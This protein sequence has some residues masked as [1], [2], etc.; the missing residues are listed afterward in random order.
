MKALQPENMLKQ[1]T[2]TRRT[3]GVFA[4]KTGRR[5]H[6]LNPAME[7]SYNTMSIHERPAGIEHAAYMD[8][9]APA[10]GGWGYFY[11]PPR[12]RYLRT[13]G[14]PVSGM[15]VAF[16]KSWGGFGGLKSRAQLEHECYTFVAGGSGVGI[17]DQLPP[18]GRLEAARYQRI[19]EVLQPIRAMEPLLCGAKPLTEAAIVLPPLGQGQLPS[20]EWAAAAKVLLEAKVQFDTVDRE[21]DWSR[22]PLLILPDQAHADAA[23]RRKLAAYLAAGGSVLATGLAVDALPA[24]RVKRIGG[25]FSAAAYYRAAP[26]LDTGVEPVPHVV[27]AGFLP[28]RT[29][30]AVALAT[31]TRAY[32]PRGPRFFFSSQ[33]P[34]AEDTDQGVVFQWNRLMYSSAPLFTEYWKTGYGAHRLLLVNCLR[35]LLPKPLVISNAPLAWEIALLRQG[36]RRLCVI[37]PYAPLRTGE[38][39]SQIAYCTP[40]MD[41][42][43]P[44]A[45]L[46][47]QVRGCFK[48]AHALARKIRVSIA[49][50]QG[51]SRLT[52]PVADGP[53]I[54]VMER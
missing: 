2:D 49:P 34:Y 14:R 4:D 10:T 31:L 27:R 23:F 30:G 26:G 43:T 24:D 17:G 51:G 22:Y 32:A 11:Y 13:L 33:I 16:H 41:D 35:R 25:A 37:V 7:I 50:A 54:V 18:R 52:L 46:E 21:A 5:I 15:T 3:V 39:G 45:G 48:E 28:V 19:A 53:M 36:R 8:I 44:M 1:V 20:P 29:R 9:E 47:I 38:L 42:W 6:A 12:A 40:Q